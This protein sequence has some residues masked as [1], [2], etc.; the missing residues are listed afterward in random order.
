LDCLVHPNFWYLKP[1]KIGV[2]SNLV[3][4]EKARE[5]L[6]GYFETFFNSVLNKTKLGNLKCSVYHTNEF[7]CLKFKCS[8]SNNEQNF[9]IEKNTTKLENMKKLNDFLVGFSLEKKFEDLYFFRKIIGYEKDY[10]YIIKPNLQ[11][12][13]HPKNAKD[14]ISQITHDIL[15]KND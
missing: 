10:F 8:K 3:K 12:Y 6:M 14:D 9:N 4:E 13:W 5:F 15:S 2:E 11:R 1:V 7:I